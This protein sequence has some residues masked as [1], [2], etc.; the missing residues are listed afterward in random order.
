M[1]ALLEVLHSLRSLVSIVLVGSLL[2]L[3]ALFVA[4]RLDDGKAIVVVGGRRA[5]GDAASRRK[6]KRSK[7]RGAS[8]YSSVFADSDELVR[9]RA[10]AI[11]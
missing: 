11:E 3:I 5:D 10:G 9:G 6:K 2:V 7:G 4:H 8:K 1:P